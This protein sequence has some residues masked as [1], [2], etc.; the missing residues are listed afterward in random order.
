MIRILPIILI[1]LVLGGV[2]YWKFFAVKEPA[3]EP[4]ET[5]I[6][7]TP[8]EVP[9]TLPIATS[10]P[11]TSSSADSGLVSKVTSLEAEVADLKSRITNLEKKPASTTSK[12]TTVSKVPVYIPLGAGGSN[13]NTNWADMPGYS[14]LIDP[15]EYNGYSSMQLEVNMRL[16]QL[17]GSAMARLSSSDGTAISSELSSAQTV[18]NLNTSLGFK[19]PTG[20]NIYKLQVK[21][22]AG[23]EMFIQDARIKVNF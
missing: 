6:V 15:G 11:T 13:S 5:G 16:N 10:S 9:A 20:K 22:T 8:K 12:S 18:N 3:P 17:G 14:I 4:V 7:Q 2:G 23:H 19:L 21:S 1:V